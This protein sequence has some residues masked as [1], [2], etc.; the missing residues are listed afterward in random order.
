[1]SKPSTP[2]KATPSKTKNTAPTNTKNTATQRGDTPSRPLTNAE[3]HARRYGRQNGFFVGR[4]D[5]R[6][7]IFNYGRN[8]SA[9]QKDRVQRRLFW[10]FAVICAVAVIGVAAFGWLNFN[11]IQPGQAIET[12]NG[13]PIQQRMYRYMVAYLTQ[14]NYNQLQGDQTQTANLNAE[15]AKDPSKSATIQPQLT[16]LQAQIQALNTSFTQTQIDQLAIDRLT[17]DVLIQHGITQLTTQDPGLTATFAFSTNDIN[18]AL[19]A[20]K[21]AFPSGET[22]ATFLRQN[23]LTNANMQDI[24]RINL[25]RAKMDAYEQSLVTS[26][27]KQVDVQRI[28]FDNLQ[29][30]QNDLAKLQSGKV[31]WEDIV[32][33][34]SI[35]VNSRDKN[36]DIGYFA[37]GQQDQGLE[38][39]AFAPNRKV[40][41]M[42]GIVKETSGLFDIVRIVAI[43]NARPLDAATVSSLKSN[44][45][46]HWLTG[47]RGLAKIST[48]NQDMYNSTY[49]IPVIPTYPAASSSTGSTGASVPLGTSTL[50]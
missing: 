37:L 36:G 33:S 48:P 2:T 17:E 5:N 35:D 24:F 32:K 45:L 38:A 4:R 27:T 21:Q 23:N 39:Y 26:P 10:A 19:T 13:A 20:F 15:L 25:R 44:A 46:S 28:Q 16:T 1:M 49:N 50:P 40:G 6:P 3:R 41:D 43:D 18:T 12:V 11:V 7:V 22:Y 42:S 34:D 14:D 29:N 30:A 8:L 47:E 31:K 9:A